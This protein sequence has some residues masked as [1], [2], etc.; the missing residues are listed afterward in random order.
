MTAQLL[1][2]A[3]SM[4]DA[5]LF[6]AQL[7]AA[8]EAEAAK[9]L[10]FYDTIDENC[11]TEFINGAVI[12]HSPVMKRHNTTT[13]YIYVLASSFAIK[14]ERGFIGIEK[15]LVSLTRND[16]EPDI[17]F[18]RADTARLF[19]ATQMQF[20]APDWIVEVLS[21]STAHIDRTIK[22]QDYAAHGV[23]EYWIVDPDAETVEQYAL[24][25]KEGEQE[26]T[27]VVKASDG[28]IRGIALEGFSVPI[29]AFFDEAEHLRALTAILASV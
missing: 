5:A 3:L 29:R 18:F 4:P 26:Y 27:I 2:T 7:Q 9:R 8:L 13:G 11:K 25:E 24:T 15:I 1:Q 19:T 17:C 14:H 22:F 6:A 21:P 10:Q 23:R 12:F 28:L 16:Y 20:P